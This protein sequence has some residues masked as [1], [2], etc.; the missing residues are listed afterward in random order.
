MTTPLPLCKN[1]ST[2][3]QD[4]DRPLSDGHTPAATVQKCVP[5]QTYSREGISNHNY[6]EGRSPWRKGFATQL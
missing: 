2:P 1:A 3:D 5:I 4:T 6:N